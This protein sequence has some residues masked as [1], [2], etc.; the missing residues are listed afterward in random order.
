[1]YVYIIVINNINVKIMLMKM[2]ML[3]HVV[4]SH[5]YGSRIG[6]INKRTSWPCRDTSWKFFQNTL[7]CSCLSNFFQV[8][9]PFQQ[10]IIYNS[11]KLNLE[12]RPTF[13][14]WFMM[15]RA[16]VV[17]GKKKI[18][19]PGLWLVQIFIN[20]V[21]LTSFDQSHATLIWRCGSVIGCKNK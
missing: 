7:S 15:A 13:F 1:M 14:I 6:K 20:S 2:I 16:S 18:A 17:I 8:Y 9:A 3:I 4:N 11:F 5:H 19:V 12:V 21:F 10:Y